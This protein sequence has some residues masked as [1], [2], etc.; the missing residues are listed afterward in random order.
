[1]QQLLAILK[2][3]CERCFHYWQEQWNKCECA[4]EAYS[5]DD[6]FPPFK[7]IMDFKYLVSYF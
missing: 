7:Y 2:I 6:S 4:G 5:K 3:K 1:M